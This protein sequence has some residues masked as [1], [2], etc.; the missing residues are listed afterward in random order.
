MDAKTNMW[1]SSTTL[2]FTCRSQERGQSWQ[3]GE[4]S[5]HY[6][7]LTSW[8]IWKCWDAWDTS[9]VSKPKTSHHRLPGEDGRQRMEA[10]DDLPLN[11]ETGHRQSDQHR[12]RCNSTIAETFKRQGWACIGFPERVDTIL[13]L[14]KRIPPTSI[15]MSS[16]VI[17]ETKSNFII[18][19]QHIWSPT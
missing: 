12:N 19:F 15:T 9:C 8:T 2:S 1:Q 10:L 13:N 14:T 5:N 16:K 6:E 3:T 4:Q 18:V 17:S 7:W 11:D